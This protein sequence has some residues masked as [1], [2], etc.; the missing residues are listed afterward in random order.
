MAHD[1]ASSAVVAS[2][3][4]ILDLF[5]SNWLTMAKIQI[6]SEKSVVLAQYFRLKCSLA[7]RGSIKQQ[8]VQPESVRFRLYA[9]SLFILCLMVQTL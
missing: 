4:K 7:V 8:G 3:S 9:L 2:V 6:K 5:I 1:E